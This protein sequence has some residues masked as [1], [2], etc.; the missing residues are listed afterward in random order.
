MPSGAVVYYR[1]RDHQYNTSE[2]FTR[3]TRV[4]GISTISKCDG[5]VSKDGLLD[6]AARLTC[7]GVAREAALGLS[8]DD[9]D[10][11]QALSWLE[12]P[13]SVQ[14]SLRHS[15]LT[16]RDL[17]SEAGDTGTDAH[18]VLEALV[19]GV[20]PLLRTGHDHAVRDWWEKRKPDPL[21]SEVVVYSPMWKCAGRF[22]LWAEID[23]VL[24]LLD[25]KT[26]KW[27][28]NSFAI[29]L[30]LYRLA[31]VDAGY[32]PVPDHLL[33][34][35]T[36][37]DGTWQEVPIPLAPAWATT[38]L[39]SYTHGKEIAAHLRAAKRTPVAA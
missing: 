35:H 7:E 22:D 12:S 38:A 8:V 26:S 17:R 10:V 5:E 1:D 37:P 9:E 6:W 33:I 29:Q 27:L 25:L 13:E 36:K 32:E 15:K 28:S 21:G 2:K 24:Y 11:R 30:N 4:P 20:T 34:L 14:D 19:D 3:A 39:N 23:Y 16:W 18:S 31:M